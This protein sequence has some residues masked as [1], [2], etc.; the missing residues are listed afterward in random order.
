MKN[1]LFNSI[2]RKTA[3]FILGLFGIIASS[4]AQMSGG[5][6]GNG[7][8]ILITNSDES[9]HDG[10]I[11]IQSRYNSNHN[12]WTFWNKLDDGNLYLHNYRSS[13]NPS[14]QTVGNHKF[15][16]SYYGNLGIGVVNPTQKLDVNGHVNIRSNLFMDDGDIRDVHSLQLK[17]WDDNTGGGDNKYRLLARDGAWQFYNGGVVVG[18]YNNGTWSDVPDGRL[19]VEHDMVI[20]DITPIVG[21]ALTVDGRVYIS[22]DVTSAEEGFDNTNND[23]YKD[24][25]LWVEEG[26]VSR[27]FAIAQTSEWPD[28]VFEGSYHMPSLE[29]VENH[30][31]AE[32]HLPNFPSAEEVQKMGYTVDDMTK[33]LVKTVEEMTLH[34]IEQ[35]KQIDAQNVLIERLMSRLDELEASK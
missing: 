5:S 26:I 14:Q 16:F 31:I 20:G 6:W 35:E 34:N 9:N 28:Y 32:G 12:H 19:I 17:D 33:R 22:D 23:N 3:F 15:T 8:D 30:I 25:L 10:A 18:N 7:S 29:E 24:Y 21:T 11:R 13:V 4:L 1:Y 2:F 27:D